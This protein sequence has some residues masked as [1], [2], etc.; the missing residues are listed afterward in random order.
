MAG[1]RARQIA[2]A[3][4]AAATLTVYAQDEQPAPTFRSEINYVQLPVRVLDADGQFVSG[5][6]QTDFQVLEDGKPQTISA[7]SAVDIPFI[8]AD[9][10]VP[11]APLARLDAVASNEA[12]QVDGRAYLFVLD[13][14]SA[15]AGDTLK[16][17]NLMHGFIRERLS[18]NDL[19]AITIVGG[20]RSQNFTRNRQLLHDAVDRFVGDRDDDTQMEM[21]ETGSV[22]G[23]IAALRRQ[24]T[25]NGITRM[26]EWLGS[27]RGRRKSLVL[28]TSSPICSLASDDCR[29][30]LQHALRVTMQSD[31]SIYVLD[32]RGLD[33]SRRSRAENSN[34]NSRYIPEIGYSEASNGAAARA[35]FAEM[36]TGLRGPLDGA[37][38]LAEE[39]GGLA[40]VNT[41]DLQRGFD[42]IVHDASSYYLLGYHSTNTRSDGKFRR[43][44][45]TVARR[46]VRVVHRNG[47]FAARQARLGGSKEQDP[48]TPPATAK[49]TIV[50]Q[51]RDLARSPLPVSAMPLRV[52]A[53]PFLSAANRARVAVVVEMPF[54]G[55]RP[56]TENGRYR[57]NIGLSIGFYD[58]D[59]KSVG[60]DEPNIDLNIPVDAAPKVTRNGMRIVS[61]IEVPPG[62]YRFWV[63]A[64]QPASGLRGSVMT[65][66]DIPDFD[67]PSLALSGI[68]VS[69]TDARRIY[70]ARTD[71]L[72]NDIFGGPPV[73]HREFSVDSD[74]WLYGEIYDH[75]SGGGE[76]TAEVTV[77][78]A[79][80]EVVHHA[81]VE[82]APVQFGHL[83][84]IPLKDI[85]TGSFVATIEA[86]STLP[87][88]ISVARTIAFQVRW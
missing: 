71:D 47:Y 39:S 12:P 84:R 27:I 23:D 32:P 30:P 3:L 86:R 57:L 69:S 79:D 70:T 18:A 24:Q 45:V 51:L 85:G 83:A 62:A 25:L 54:E 2:V 33:P 81:P 46:G 43:N 55:L 7:F 49:S 10:T 4:A 73:A 29:E 67:K 61:R 87:K 21:P 15:E 50:E 64:V 1:Y 36:R 41:N 59:G 60:G 75:R 44:Q 11:A 68:A 72:L 40:V 26:A 63:G 56:A 17:R 74:L 28:I 65:E 82:A 76:V 88:P 80:G 6:T 5:L 20:A 13:D 38:Y 35:A 22:L 19:A 8:P 37:R 42:R 9:S 14:F 78:S 31:V 58:R 34:P 48:A 77:K 52:S 66:I 53:T 16:V